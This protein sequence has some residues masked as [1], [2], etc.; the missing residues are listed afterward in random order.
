MK[1]GLTVGS[2]L[3]DEEIDGVD[4]RTDSCSIWIASGECD[5]SKEFLLFLFA[6]F[7]VTSASELTDILS[8]LLIPVSSEVLSLDSAIMED[9]NDIKVTV[10]SNNESDLNKIKSLDTIGGAIDIE[11]NTN[12]RATK[13]LLIEKK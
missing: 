2:I 12:S 3:S 5:I 4:I 6:T 7:L 13:D 8:K 11:Y 1:S 10:T 9:N